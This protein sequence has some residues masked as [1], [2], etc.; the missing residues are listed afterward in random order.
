MQ[1][2]MPIFWIVGLTVVF[3][4]VLMI[5]DYVKTKSRKK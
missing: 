2:W 5:I 3:F 1:K 4:A